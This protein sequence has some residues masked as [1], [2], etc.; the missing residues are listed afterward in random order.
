MIYLK[1]MLDEYQVRFSA[2]QFNIGR[3]FTIHRLYFTYQQR[4]T[5]GK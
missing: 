1:S 2:K 3:S 4:K 5:K